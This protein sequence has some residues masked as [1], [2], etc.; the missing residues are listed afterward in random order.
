MR[1]TII[2]E[3]GYTLVET[4]VA[5]A[6]FLGVLVP[7]G[8]GIAA[9]L[10]DKKA[11]EMRTAL[12]LAETRLSVKDYR[13]S[14]EVVGGKFIVKEEIDLTADLLE[15]KVSVFKT[16]DRTRSIITLRKTVPAVP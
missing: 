2:E 15:V 12:F 3:S 11:E 4:L 13:Q 1:Q 6:L 14:E 9:L 16:N 5:M 8:F 7:V 10:F